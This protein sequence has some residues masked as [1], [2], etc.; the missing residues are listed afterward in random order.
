MATSA[1]IVA[2][3][4]HLDPPHPD[5]IVNLVD[6]RDVGIAL[7][8]FAQ[9]DEVPRRILF[10]GGNYRLQ[11]MLEQLAERY[12]APPP[13]PPLTAE[14]AVA[15][16]DA[17]EAR[18]AEE[19]GRPAISREIVDLIVHSFDLDATLAEQV[20]GVQWT[21]ITDTLDAYD[22]WARPLGIL[23]KDIRT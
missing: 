18:C 7:T 20:L 15:L 22:A 11:P 1:L 23:P 6:V 16:A 19:G 17:E 8:R 12:G 13:G 10:C 5:G 3:A 2:M 21:P 14:E 9:L 4:R